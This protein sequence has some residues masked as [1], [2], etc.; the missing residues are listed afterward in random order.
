[1]HDIIHVQVNICQ[2]DTSTCTHGSSRNWKT[3]RI[4]TAPQ[5]RKKTRRP[6][7]RKCGGGIHSTNFNVKV[8]SSATRNY[9]QQHQLHAAF[10]QNK[11]PIYYYYY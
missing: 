11:T 2:E 7:Q 5:N 1:M 8:F 10:I 3:S 9:N 4:V 6:R